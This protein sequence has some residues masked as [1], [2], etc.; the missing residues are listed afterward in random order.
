M[1]LIKQSSKEKANKF[2]TIDIGNESDQNIVN[3]P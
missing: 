1:E 2:L 3:A